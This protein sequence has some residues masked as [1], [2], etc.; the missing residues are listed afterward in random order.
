M[1]DRKTKI[2]IAVASLGYFVD[3]FDLILFGVVR[4]PSLK[5]LGLNEQEILE[6]GSQ[7][8]NFQLIGGLIGGILFGILGDKKGRKSVLFA[9]IIIY[10][11]ANFLNG[12]VHDVSTYLVLRFIAGIGLAGE[13]G[14]GVT[15]VSETMPKAIR[16]YGSS[17]IATFG[18]L[19][20]LFAPL[21]F[22]IAGKINIPI[23]VW[24]FTYFFG[25]GMGFLLLFLR[26]GVMESVLFNN[27]TENK[28]NILLLFQNRQRFV[29]YFFCILLG[30]PV[31]YLI[32][33]LTIP[34]R[35]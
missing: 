22:K 24:R 11:L 19:G 12:F 8:F 29:K 17:I 26:I 6:K 1:L 23:E 5:S 25:G 9:S 14:V 7:I 27:Q 30:L 2:L 21:V 13:L 32:S 3:A 28:G 10:S 4:S 34:R 16:G 33:I 18:A 15:L 20:A 31:W 35:W